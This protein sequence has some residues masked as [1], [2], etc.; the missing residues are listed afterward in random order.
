MPRPA[1]VH[2]TR[3]TNVSIDPRYD[4]WSLSAVDGDSQ[5]TA[6]P[7]RIPDRVL[8]STEETRELYSAGHGTAPDLTYAREVPNSPHPDPTSFNKKLCI[9]IVV[10]IG[11]S[12]YL[13]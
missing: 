13:S 12:R 4:T 1:R 5:C 6:A 8:D 11:F 3:H 2:R 7:P 9:L 10:E